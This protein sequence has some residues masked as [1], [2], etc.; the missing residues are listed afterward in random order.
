MSGEW[1][2]W[3][4]MIDDFLAL[5]AR[6]FPNTANRLPRPAQEG[7]RPLPFAAYR[8]QFDPEFAR[9]DGLKAEFEPTVLA[10]TSEFSPLLIY[11]AFHRTDVRGETKLLLL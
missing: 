5:G 2:A 9:G 11:L 10:K 3:S 6:H 7:A 4:A 8:C 1:G